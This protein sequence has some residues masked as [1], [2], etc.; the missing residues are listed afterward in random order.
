MHTEGGLSIQEVPLH[1]LESA[2]RNNFFLSLSLSL[3]KQATVW[4]HRISTQIHTHSTYLWL[5]SRHTEPRVTATQPRRTNGEPIQEAK[6]TRTR[7]ALKKGV[8][9]QSTRV[10]TVCVWT[11]SSQQKKHRP[12]ARGNGRWDQSGEMEGIEMWK[13]KEGRKRVM[14][15][16]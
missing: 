16:K 3:A 5:C 12:V 11:D 13:D 10:S 4:N 8:R 7:R 15:H 14:H 2:R 9:F 6:M 1:V